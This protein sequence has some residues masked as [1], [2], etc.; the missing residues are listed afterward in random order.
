MA[1]SLLELCSRGSSKA[2]SCSMSTAQKTGMMPIHTEAVVLVRYVL[3][4][5]EH[6][7]RE[8]K[9]M[10]KFCEGDARV[11][12]HKKGIVELIRL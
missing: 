9:L 3:H 1:R 4:M 7:L 10:L 2:Q 11:T 8:E 12:Y 5:S 6:P